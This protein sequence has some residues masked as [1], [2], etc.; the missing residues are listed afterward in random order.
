MH[1]RFKDGDGDFVEFNG[2]LIHMYVNMPSS[3]T[4]ELSEDQ[5]VELRDVLTDWLKEM[6]NRA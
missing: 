4:T 2:G 1:A 6:R 3:T 5:V